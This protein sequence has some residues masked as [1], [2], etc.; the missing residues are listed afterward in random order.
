[1]ATIRKDSHVYYNFVISNATTLNIPAKFTDTQTENIIDDIQNYHLACIKF[2]I[3]T[4]AISIM[5]LPVGSAATGQTSGYSISMVGT[6]GTTSQSFLSYVPTGNI[7]DGRINSYST[8]IDLINTSFL[9]AASAIGATANGDYPYMAFDSHAQLF[10]IYYPSTYIA[11]KTQ[12]WFNSNMYNL[13]PSFSYVFN[14][15]RAYS[16]SN[17]GLYVNIN[18]TNYGQPDSVAVSNYNQIIQEYSSTISLYQPR[19]IRIV[20]GTVP[21]RPEIIPAIG[22]TATLQGSASTNTQQILT[23]FDLPVGNSIAEI[24]PYLQYYQV[25]PYRYM[26]LIGSGKLKVFDMTIF[27]VNYLGDSYPLYIA[28]NEAATFKFLFCRK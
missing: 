23:D 1:M 22:G 20:C 4:S 26:D 9:N 21:S 28:P 25:G 16:Y 27:V 19:S 24:K 17:S 8:L 11:N 6:G 12:I 10:S 5:Y 18:L 7:N 15:G 3:P 2:V 13:F 14:N